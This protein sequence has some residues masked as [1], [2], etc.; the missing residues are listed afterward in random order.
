MIDLAAASLAAVFDAIP[1]GLAVVDPG[2]RIVL[3]NGAFRESL[4]LPADAIPPGTPVADAVHAAALRGVYGPGDP[5]A[6]VVRVMA[7]GRSRPGLLRRRAFA[8]RHFDL[9]N[10]PMQDGGYIVTCV[11]T[12]AH[13][14]RL[15]LTS[16]PG[17]GTTVRIV[18]PGRAF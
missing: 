3:M 17:H 4:D 9:S 12:T 10:T 11:V 16:Q 15:D 2:Q 5:Q 18:L 14:G 1:V 7:P 8:G 6:Q 13:G